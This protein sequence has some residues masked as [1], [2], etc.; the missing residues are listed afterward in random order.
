MQA[1]K[2][3]Q[4]II[5]DEAKALLNAALLSPSRR[6]HNLL[7]RWAKES[8]QPLAE[9]G[10]AEA[11]WLICTMPDQSSEQIS[12]EEFDRRRLEQARV[13]ANAGSASAQFF[14][15]CELD[16]A[17][18]TIKESSEL[19]KQ[20]AQ[21]GHTYA[22]WCY[23]LNLLSGRGV[24]KNQSLGLRYI[25]EAAN[26]KFEGA[27]QFLSHAYASGTYGYPTNEEIAATWWAKLRDGDV[28]H[29]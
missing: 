14:L 27:I 2:K 23:G 12:H 26:E 6:R 18:D 9:E 3:E 4:R 28:I 5:I 13:Y 8:L 17:A 25:E 20:A 24:E 7:L 11:L 1:L 10:V 29:Y 22:K 15:A 19:F 16:H 21:Q